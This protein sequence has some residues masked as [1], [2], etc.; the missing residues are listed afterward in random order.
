[1]EDARDHALTR[2]LAGAIA[3]TGPAR[4]EGGARA[5]VA[6]AERHRVHVLL[7]ERALEQS[8]V[9]GRQSSADGRQSERPSGVGGPASGAGG[10]ATDRGW[11]ADVAASLSDML[12]GAVL[13][14]AV[15]HDEAVRV[16]SALHAAGVRAVVFKGGALAYTVYR[17]PYLRP[18]TDTDILIAKADLPAVERAFAALGYARPAETSGGLITQQCHFDRTDP[19]GIFHAWDVHWK[20]VNVQAVADAL[21]YEEIVRDASALPAL[22]SALAPSTAASLVLAC[23]HRVAHHGDSPN[24]LWLLDIHLLAGRMTAADW[25]PLVTNA[26]ARGVWAACAQSLSR[27]RERFGTAL[28]PAVAVAIDEP[29]D[30]ATARF[31]DPGLRQIDVMRADLA[32]LPTWSA[33]CQLVREHVF[34]PAA[35]MAARYGVRH[36]VMLPWWYMRR[37]CAGGPK[38][39]RRLRP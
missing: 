15:R 12:A 38:W 20:V 2:R 27:A 24:L 35:F 7:A 1:M 13:V 32:A 14:D 11:P 33:R 5:W 28:P 39:F 26:R 9:A 3:G 19:S 16:L 17:R 23:L 21:T 31:L 4:P 22:A 36:R 30:D 37:L 29:C 25:P 34:P 18:R 6:A 10:P 8:S